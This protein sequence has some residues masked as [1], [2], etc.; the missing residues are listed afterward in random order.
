M[1]LKLYLKSITPS[2]AKLDGSGVIYSIGQ[3]NG[4]NNAERYLEELYN[5]GAHTNNSES[6]ANFMQRIASTVC[7]IH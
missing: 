1:V 6:V 2:I 5:R 3:F 4:F 7:S